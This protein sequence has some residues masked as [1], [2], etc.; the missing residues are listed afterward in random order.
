[1]SSLKIEETPIRK[2]GKMA[3]PVLAVVMFLVIGT[4]ESL[5]AGTV[6]EIDPSSTGIAAMALIAGAVLLI[7]GRRSK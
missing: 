2:L 4:P 6:P 1:M 3:L 5:W 7:R